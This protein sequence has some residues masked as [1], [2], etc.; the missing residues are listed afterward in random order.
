MSF[1]WK[2]CCA[3]SQLCFFG[4]RGYNNP[5]ILVVHCEKH[6][7]LAFCELYFLLQDYDIFMGGYVIVGEGSMGVCQRGKN[8]T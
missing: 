8:Y 5:V 7:P 4:G 1:S 2:H 6:I 3:C